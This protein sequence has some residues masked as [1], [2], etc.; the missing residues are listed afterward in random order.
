MPSRHALDYT[1][2]EAPADWYAVGTWMPSVRWSCTPT[3]SFLSG[4][5]LGDAVLWH[6]E[7]FTGE[8][9]LE[10]FLGVKM[11][12]PREQVGYFTRYHGY[13]AVTI[14]GDG[15]DPRNGYCG[16]YGAPDAD[17]NPYQRAELLRNG[18]IVAAIPINSMRAWRQNHHQWFKLMLNKQGN[19]VTFSVKL[20]MRRYELPYTDPQP[21]DGGIPAIWTHANAISLARVLLNCEHA[22]TPWAGPQVTID[23]PWYPEWANIAHPETL[24]FPESW[25]I[26]GKPVTLRVTPRLT[27]PGTTTRCAAGP[28]RDLLPHATGRAL[29]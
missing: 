28:A 29:V 12:F 2:A 9:S 21:I 26:S 17:G 16:I 19:T 6:K 25:A 27:P 1:F 5:S 23:T 22:P 18:V 8:Q 7:R 10:A 11:E 14:C 24:A 15:K 13:L 3:W 4:W 20:D